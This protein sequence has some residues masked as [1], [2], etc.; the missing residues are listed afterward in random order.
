MNMKC[1]RCSNTD[2]AYFYFDQGV[3]Y[4]RKC[5]MFSRLDANTKIKPVSLTH[6]IIQIQPKLKYEL[7]TKQKEV[8]FKVCQLLKEGNDVFLYACTGAGKTEITLESICYYL[9]Q[10]KKVGFAISR[11]QV[12]LE[13]RDRL[14]KI[15]PSLHIVAVTQGYTKDTDGDIIV[16]TMH[17]LYR[18]PYAFDLLIMD[19]VDAF[20]Y[21]G[22]DVL[23]SIASL[24]CTGQKLYLSATPDKTLLEKS[25]VVTLFQ[26]PHGK[27]L[28]IPEVIVSPVFIQLFC[29][30]YY[31]KKWKE[32]QCLIFVPRRKDCIWLHYFLLP[33]VSNS[34]IHSQITNKDEIIDQFHQKK[35]QCL[36]STTLLE[37][38]ITI[39]DVSVIVFST[40]HIVYTVSTLIQIL[41]RVGR[42]FS[43]PYGKGVLLCQSISPS[44]KECI[45]QLKQM[46]KNVESVMIK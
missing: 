9:S 38:G 23:S 20:P 39:P 30:L 28:L 1:Y 7:T 45:H 4:C 27:P 6:K 16:C 36:I 12:V 13:I 32:K 34:F 15:F 43:D 42:S 46:N 26:R 19:E 11:R 22:N 8:S 41:G 37:R 21:I 33:F 44:I 5:I 18:Y 40:D 25:K 29:I 24:S 14:Q 17:Q 3:Y 2:P 35:F 31:V 10:G